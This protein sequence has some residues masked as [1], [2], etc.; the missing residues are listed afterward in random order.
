[1][2]ED[3]FKQKI[4]PAKWVS[5]GQAAMAH[6]IYDESLKNYKSQKKGEKTVP[7]D[8]VPYEIRMRGIEQLV[9]DHQFKKLWEKNGDAYLLN[10]IGGL[11]IKYC[12]SGDGRYHPAHPKITLS[13]R[14]RELKRCAQKL[15]AMVDIINSDI[16]ISTCFQAAF[17]E[18]IK[19]GNFE[20]KNTC[21]IGAF[22][23]RL[24]EDLNDEVKSGCRRMKTHISYP[25]SIR[26]KNKAERGHFIYR[27]SKHIQYIYKRYNHALVS[28]ILNVLR[29]D[30]GEFTPE[31]V[32]QY[33]SNKEKPVSLDK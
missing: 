6:Q 19:A 15:S 21:N 3:L 17:F 28:R 11:Y 8:I 13:E 12:I 30:L 23:I 18:A 29:P 24:Y 10:T 32:R 27:I 1:M 26:E 16:S 4:Q 14:D 5:E 22:L 2:K 33:I 25:R 20:T 7:P 31:D 9:T